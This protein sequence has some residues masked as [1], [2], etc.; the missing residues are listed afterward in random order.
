MFF[1]VSIGIPAGVLYPGWLIESPPV[2][3]ALV[4][5]LGFPLLFLERGLQLQRPVR[6]GISL[7]LFMVLGILT[8]VVILLPML[9]FLAVQLLENRKIRFRGALWATPVVIAAFVFLFTVSS[10]SWK[11]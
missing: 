1:I 7:L 10:V 11:N 8:K 4:L 5:A 6:I 3:I 2:A 9:I